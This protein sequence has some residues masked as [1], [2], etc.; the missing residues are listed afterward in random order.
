MARCKR[1]KMKVVYFLLICLVSCGT[2]RDVPAVRES[3]K[4]VKIVERGADN[5]VWFV[6]WESQDGTQ[7]VYET[8]KTKPE[9]KV[10]DSITGLII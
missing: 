3:F 5:R 10:G 1:S 6:I 8:Y 2:I 7:R 9:I 4:C